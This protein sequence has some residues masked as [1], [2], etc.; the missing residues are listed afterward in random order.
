MWIGIFWFSDKR[1]LKMNTIGQFISR[2]RDDLTLHELLNQQSST[3]SQVRRKPP[4]IQEKDN[5]GHKKET[6]RSC[7]TDYSHNIKLTNTNNDYSTTKLNKINK[8]L[9]KWIA[10]NSS[11]WRLLWIF[12]HDIRLVFLWRGFL[13]FLL[14]SPIRIQS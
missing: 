7:I 13:L 8:Q 2:N 14:R 12:N 10:N 5:H 11:R 1:R 9:T 4:K 6:L 3:L